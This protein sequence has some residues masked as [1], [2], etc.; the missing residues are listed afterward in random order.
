MG[1]NLFSPYY[2]TQE[3]NNCPVVLVV[4]FVR[5]EER[6]KVTMAWDCCAGDVTACDCRDEGKE[7]LFEY[8]WWYLPLLAPCHIAAY[9][10][11]LYP[12]LP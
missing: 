4:E 3:K 11:F 1:R 5:I 2:Y 8:H 9:I 10:I 7:R 12:A 6:R